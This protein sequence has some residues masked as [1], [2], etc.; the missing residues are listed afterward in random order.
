MYGVT[1]NR[2]PVQ[3]LKF[4]GWLLEYR[5]VQVWTIAKRKQNPVGWFLI[6]LQQTLELLIAAMQFNIIL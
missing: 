1:Q 3:I 4:A 2:F 6:S 5:Y